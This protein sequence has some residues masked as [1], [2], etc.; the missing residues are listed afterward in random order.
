MVTRWHVVRVRGKCVAVVARV[1]DS[2]GMARA[3]EGEGG[4]Y[5]ACQQDSRPVRVASLTQAGGAATDDEDVN[6]DGG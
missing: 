2:A 1:E 4:S 6:G 5:E 3:A